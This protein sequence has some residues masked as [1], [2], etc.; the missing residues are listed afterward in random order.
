MKTTD[1][2]NYVQQKNDFYLLHQ[3][4]PEATHPQILAK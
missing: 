2:E 1:F 4:L 3:Q